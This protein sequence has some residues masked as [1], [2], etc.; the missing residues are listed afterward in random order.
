VKKK[1]AKKQAALPTCERLKRN[2]FEVTC[3]VESTKD[4]QYFLLRSDVHH[5]STHCNRTLEK[6]HLEQVKERNGLVFDF[7]DCYDVMQGRFDRRSSKDDLREE[8]KQGD[9]L[10]ALVS[11]FAQ[12]YTPYANN[13]GM[14]SMGNH[15]TAILKHH[16]TNLTE[17]LIDR[18]NVKTGSNIHVGGYSGWI[19]FN[20]VYGKVG[21]HVGKD[22]YKRKGSSTA[23][24]WLWYHHGYGGDAPV[25]KG[26]IQTARQSPYLPDAN[27][28]VT[29]HTHNEWI[30]PIQR[31]R[32]K[33]TG[34]V[35]QDEQLHVKCAGYKEEYEDGHS[36]WH[37]E[38]GGPPKPNG[39]M[40]L[41][42]GWCKSDDPLTRG[43][44][45]DVTRA[46]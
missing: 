30:F 33:D 9:Y 14:M 41:K 24:I 5:D 22:G 1:S 40:W 45:Y 18:L 8:Y 11:D 37:I 32:I 25:T 34:T 26:T 43:M 12:Y 13:I 3:N 31:I 42:L 38:R 4:F 16:E 28:C 29:G 2:V 46:K 19:R 21:A 6:K 7:G 39:A 15:E 20:V 10:D 44:T 36:G 23:S 35:Y 17:R 27:I